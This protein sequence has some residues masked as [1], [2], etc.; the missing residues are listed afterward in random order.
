MGAQADE[1]KKNLNYVLPYL[2]TFPTIV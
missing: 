1:K 2:T